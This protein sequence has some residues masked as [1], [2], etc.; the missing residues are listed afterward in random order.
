MCILFKI[1]RNNYF[2]KTNLNIKYTFKL[3]KKQIL[4]AF[5]ICL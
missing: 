1:K 5:K 3:I 2:L 4:I